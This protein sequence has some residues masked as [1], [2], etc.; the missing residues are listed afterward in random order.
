MREK[1]YAAL[2]SFEDENGILYWYNNEG[3]HISD[4]IDQVFEDE[5]YDSEEYSIDSEVVFSSPAVD[6]GYI[7]VAWI[8]WGKLHHETYIIG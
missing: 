2:E 3:V 6:A 1:I 8:D 4:A 7:S 5:D